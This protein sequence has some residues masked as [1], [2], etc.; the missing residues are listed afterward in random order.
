LNRKPHYFFG[1]VEARYLTVFSGTR[2]S[3]ETKEKEISP[4]LAIWSRYCLL[5]LQWI[6]VRLSQVERSRFAWVVLSPKK[7]ECSGGTRCNLKSCDLSSSQVAFCIV[8]IFF[9]DNI[10]EGE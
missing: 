2:D 9:I 1:E 8:V 10:L 6:T 3:D 7:R 4:K 5:G